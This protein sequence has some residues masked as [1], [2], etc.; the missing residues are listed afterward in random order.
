[1]KTL[2]LTTLLLGIAAESPGFTQLLLSKTLDHP[3][4]IEDVEGALWTS[5]LIEKARKP[6]FDVAQDERMLDR[7][8]VG[9]GPAG[10]GGRGVGCVRNRR[11][12]VARRDALCA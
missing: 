2:A 8:L 4:R 7:I 11:R 5:A 12:G 3:R 10:G 9:L 6:P 1:M